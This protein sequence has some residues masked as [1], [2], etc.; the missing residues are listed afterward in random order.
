MK[1]ASAV[2]FIFDPLIY[3][4][5]Y[6]HFGQ[7]SLHSLTVR[8]ICSYTAQIPFFGL[9]P[10]FFPCVSIPINLHPISTSFLDFLQDFPHFPSH[11]DSSFVLSSSMTAHPPTFT[12]SDFSSSSFI[13]TSLILP[14]YVRHLLYWISHY[15]CVITPYLITIS[16]T[17]LLHTLP[18]LQSKIT[19]NDDCNC[20]CCRTVESFV[21]SVL[22]RYRQQILFPVL[23]LC[24]S[25]LTSMGSENWQA[26][27]QV[28]VLSSIC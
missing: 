12:F 18:V 19:L 27:R 3:G 13:A 9:A 16:P 14:F 22:S 25:L 7:S 28:S 8:E 4:G 26:R 20:F 1:W 24:L 10:I 23:R 15:P 21:P 2:L 11:S 17:S 6:V 5:L